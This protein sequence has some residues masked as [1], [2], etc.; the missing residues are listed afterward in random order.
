MLSVFP[1][2]G[3]SLFAC[4]AQCIF[5]LKEK[6]ET[7]RRVIAG[8]QEEPAFIIFKLLFRILG[9]YKASIR[10][11][12]KEMYERNLI[13]RVSTTRAFSD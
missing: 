13:T 4:F 11:R 9:T 10:Y 8:R 3:H 7:G 5:V 12:M 1:F 6:Q 2:L